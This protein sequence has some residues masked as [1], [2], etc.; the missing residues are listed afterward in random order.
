M[1]SHGHA[2]R[3]SDDEPPPPPDELDAVCRR[4]LADTMRPCRELPAWERHDDAA[5]ARV[6]NT[7]LAS[8]YGH[9]ETGK[10][11]LRTG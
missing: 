7:I 1:P 11:A 9:G 8:W 2:Q 10:P 4:M 6:R 3:P 5:E